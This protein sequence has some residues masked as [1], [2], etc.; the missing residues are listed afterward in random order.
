MKKESEKLYKACNYLQVIEPDFYIKIGIKNDKINNI[1]WGE[2]FQ[3]SGINKN[4]RKVII[5]YLKNAIKYMKL[6]D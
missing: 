1:N 3:F 2:M 6:K 5:K 4:Y